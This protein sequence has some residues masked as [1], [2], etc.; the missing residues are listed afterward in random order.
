[1]SKHHFSANSASI[2]GHVEMTSFT[3]G[4][5]SS[6]MSDQLYAANTICMTCSSKLGDLVA[7]EEKGFFKLQLPSLLG[8][9]KTVPYAN[10]LRIK[11]LRAIG[12]VMAKLDKSDEPLAK[13][14]LA[15]YQLLFK[16]TEASFWIT[17]KDLP[18]DRFW[19]AF[20]VAALM[21]KGVTSSV[22]TS[23]SS[24]HEYW[25]IRDSSV[26]ATAAESLEAHGVANAQ[27][28]QAVT[29]TNE[30]VA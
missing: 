30:A 23:I 16:V 26:L 21:R 11:R 24:V 10:G 2:C 29:I 18:F 3:Y 28:A 15:V 12:P 7:P 1:M 17:T 25:R 9:T 13:V 20:E 19:M 6:R 22:R 14:A 5:K 8:T 4:S 27:L